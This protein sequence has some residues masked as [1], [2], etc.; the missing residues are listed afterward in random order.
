MLVTYAYEIASLLEK[1]ST[2][3]V[4]P[5]TT[6]SSKPVSV[7]SVPLFESIEEKEEK[8]EVVEPVAETSMARPSPE[9]SSGGL[10]ESIPEE[11]ETTKVETK[12]E[13]ISP[14]K[15]DVVPLSMPSDKI[16]NAAKEAI[17][18]SLPRP[19]TVPTPVPKPTAP[20]RSPS[21]DE[22]ERKAI[23]EALRIIGMIGKKKK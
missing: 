20:T 17:P 13:T 8:P 7:E 12:L 18:S 10:F 9:P 15:E 22:E 14:S 21:V 3:G 16:P 11:H 1:V 4:T 23:M 2:E 5:V 6:V 19:K